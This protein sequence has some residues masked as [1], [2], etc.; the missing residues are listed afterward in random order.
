MFTAAIAAPKISFAIFAIICSSAWVNTAN[1]IL[2]MMQSCNTDGENA[3][4][5][6]ASATSIEESSGEARIANVG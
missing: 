2:S 6:E 3:E 5:F 4:A 1:S